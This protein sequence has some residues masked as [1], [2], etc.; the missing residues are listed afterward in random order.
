M[1]PWP[2]LLLLLGLVLRGRAA[3]TPPTIPPPREPAAAAARKQREATPVAQTGLDFSGYPG[4]PGARGGGRQAIERD[5]GP[6][7]WS[8]TAYRMWQD[9]LKAAADQKLNTNFRMRAQWLRD[10]LFAYITGQ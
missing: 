5:W 1:N 10:L 3:A 7:V 8:T 4:R 2:L 6:G 9:T